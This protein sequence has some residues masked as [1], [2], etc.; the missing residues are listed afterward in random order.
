MRCP[1]YAI[2]LHRPP[3]A[4]LGACRHPTKCNANAYD[5]LGRLYRRDSEVIGAGIDERRDLGSVTAQD[6][7][8][9][10]IVPRLEPLTKL[11]ALV[12]DA[13]EADDHHV[14]SSVH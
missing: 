12:E 14:E 9:A 4:T 3:T 2:D 6:E 5:D 8:G 10:D 11:K 1:F 13:R 7:N